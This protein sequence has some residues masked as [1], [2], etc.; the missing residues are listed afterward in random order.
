MTVVEPQPEQRG[1]LHR[2][3]LVG[4]QQLLANDS[5]L[6]WSIIL[7][8]WALM[9]LPSVTGQAQF[10]DHR[11][12][13]EHEGTRPWLLQLLL[14]LLAWQVMTGAM[15]LPT[16]LP[17]VRLFAKASSGQEKPRLALLTFLAA[18]ATVW[19]G[20]AILTFVGDLGLHWFMSHWHWLHTRPQLIS[21]VTLLM[22]GAFQ[23]SPLKESC[24]R[25]CQNPMSFLMQYYQ[26]GLQAAWSL[27]SRHGLYC[28][29]CCWALMLV[30]FAVGV[31]NLAWMMALT[32][33]MLIEKT[34]L[35]GQKLARVMGIM[36]LVGGSFLLLQ[37]S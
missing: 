1:L 23:F 20:F 22:A 14:F 36:L 15:M 28:L 13:M 6:V 29:G 4:F 30:M 10:L 3:I 21:G 37:P 25:Q 34:S 16:S 19:S 2:R 9:L 8:A 24:L 17:M 31:G 27:G 5:V 26:R 33:V 18:Y 11:T 32:G 12:L 35:Q 7:I